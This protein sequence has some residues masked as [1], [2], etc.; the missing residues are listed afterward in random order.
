MFGIVVGM[1]QNTQTAV[2]QEIDKH[3]EDEVCL[4]KEF[5]VSLNLILFKNMVK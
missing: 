4:I 5:S 1:V 3:F 2:E